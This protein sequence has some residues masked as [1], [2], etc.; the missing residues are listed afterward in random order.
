MDLYIFNCVV[1]TMEKIKL[2]IVDQDSCFAEQ[3]HHFLQKFPD[4]EIIGR[5]H[6][7]H[8]ALQRIRTLHPDAVL[9]DLVL[10]GMDGI[11]LLRKVNEM[12]YPPAMV[13]CTRFYSDVAL[14]ALRTFGA[15]YVLFKPIE[16][17]SIH[18]AIFSC[19]QFH[20]K[21]RHTNHCNDSS[22]ANSEISNNHI[23]NHI[24]AL[25][26][27]SKLIGCSYLTEAVRLARNDLSLTRN[28]SKGLYLEISRSMKT[29]PTRIERCIRNAISAAY[30]NGALDD[31]MVSCPSNKEFINYLL[32]TIKV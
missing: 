6:D 32:R 26:I 24:V 4:I 15:A 28:L 9:F 30:Q 18:P 23:R 19:T 7:G 21:L 22:A 3:V 2:L 25:G 29:S 5:E 16:L 12:N 8:D 1:S 31:K 17:Q 20:Q 10:P 13:C 14:E 11:A 27:P